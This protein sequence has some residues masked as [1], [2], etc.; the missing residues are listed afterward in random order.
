MSPPVK[1]NHELMLNILIIAGWKDGH[2]ECTYCNTIVNPDC[3]SP[4]P[5][6]GINEYPA[7][8]GNR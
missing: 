2:V 8:T 6:R 3:K 7:R 4:E 5:D 1:C